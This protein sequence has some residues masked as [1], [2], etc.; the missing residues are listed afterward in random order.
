VSAC[1]PLAQT[2][3]ERSEVLLRAF[4]LRRASAAT[5]CSWAPGP[6]VLPAAAYAAS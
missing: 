5:R 4:I 1:A 6:A 3:A 2:D